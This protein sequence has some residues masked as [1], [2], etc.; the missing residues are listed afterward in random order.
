M[1][2][3]RAEDVKMMSEMVSA[4]HKKQS[5]E[6]AREVEKVQSQTRVEVVQTCREE[7]KAVRK[8]TELKMEDKVR[9]DE[10]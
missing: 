2:S 4:V 5:N 6:L 10:V 9:V 1:C 7:V 3:D 8:W